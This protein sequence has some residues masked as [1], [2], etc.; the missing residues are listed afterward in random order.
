LETWEV[1]SIIGQAKRMGAVLISLSGG[2]PLLREDIVELVEYAHDIGLLTRI[3]TN[4]LLLN[5]EC[6]SKLKKA[7]LTQC[8][9][10]ID[11]AD[12]ETHDRLRGVPG[13]HK[14]ALAGIRYLREFNIPSE[15]ISYAAKRNVTAGLQKVIK[16]GRQIGVSSI[17]IVFPV[18]AGH[19]DGAF[20]QLLSEPEKARVR[21]LQDLRLVHVEIAT[22]WSACPVSLRSLLSILPYGDVTPCACVPFVIGNIRKHTLSDLWKRYSTGLDVECRGDCIMNKTQAREAVKKHVE[23]VAET[24][25]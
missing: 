22:P 4:G 1:K 24:L 25:K 3:N 8:A 10:S 14:K 6:V 12:P 18:A 7:G 20:E 17:C 5:R 21:G 15:I 2:E 19:L 9:V 23:L 16:L 13:T 11:D